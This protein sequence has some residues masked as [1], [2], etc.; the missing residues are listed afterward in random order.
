MKSE[1]K[2]FILG[3]LLLIFALFEYKVHY[4]NF[5]SF[6]VSIIGTIGITMIIDSFD[7]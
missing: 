3:I 1:T 2:K 7:D 5:N 4:F 6:F